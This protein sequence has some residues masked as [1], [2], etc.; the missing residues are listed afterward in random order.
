MGSGRGHFNL[1]TH[2]PNLRCLRL[3]FRSE[4]CDS[5]LLL[6]DSSFQF[7]DFTMFFE[8]FVEQHRVYC[9]VTDGEKFAVL[10]ANYQIGI[11]LC[12]FFS[13]QT[14]LRRVITLVGKRHQPQVQDRPAR[15]VHRFDVVFKSARGAIGRA[16]LAGRVDQHLHRV[17]GYNS[18]ANVAYKAAIARVKTS[19]VCADADDVIGGGN[20][21]SGII[22]QGCVA[23]TRRVVKERAVT[24]SCVKVAVGVAGKGE[25]SSS[26]IT[27]TAATIQKRPSANSSIFVRVCEKERSSADRCVEVSGRERMPR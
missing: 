21:V 27:E 12:Y 4:S 5:F 19:D 1:R 26:R 13:D 15:I 9:V 23:D 25:R 14:K 20:S 24:D 3:Y 2:F 8:E 17:G 7:F 11:Y 10:V 18:I 16:Q 6:G 22:A